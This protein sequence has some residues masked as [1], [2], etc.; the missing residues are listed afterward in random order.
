MTFEERAKALVSQMTLAEKLANEGGRDVTKLS[1]E[2]WDAYY[3][4][5]KQLIKEGAQNDE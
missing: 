2:E 3:R 4:K 1:P 5:A